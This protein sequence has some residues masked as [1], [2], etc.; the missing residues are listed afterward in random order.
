MLNNTIQSSISSNSRIAKNAILL[1][2]RMGLL[3][4][5]QLYTIPI[6]LKNL[7][8]EDY[9]VYNVIGSFVTLFSFI[10]T[11]L[12]SG[13]QRFISF[14]LGKRDTEELRKIVNITVTIYLVFAIILIVLL[15]SVG[16]WFLN[17]KM[18]I[19][20]DRIDT[21]NW[22]FQ[23]SIGA[24][25]FRLLV[26][27]YNAVIIAHEKMNF[28]AY[29]SIIDCILK[30]VS[31]ILLVY[32]L[33]D[34][35]FAYALLIWAVA[36]II[37]LMTHLYCKSRFAECHK[38]RLLWNDERKVQLLTYSGWNMIGSVAMIMRQ[39]GVNVIQNIFFGP[40]INAAHTIGQQ[41]MGGIT[42]IVNNIY[43]ASRPPITKLYA[44]GRNDDMWR[45]V[46]SSGKL[47]YFL[48][49]FI[50]IPL[51]VE[52]DTILGLWLHNVP[53][54]T[55]HI[56]RLMIIG[57]LIETLSNQIIAAYQA[58]NKIKRYQLYSSTIILCTL[59]IS[60]LWLR[61]DSASV[62]I[63]YAVSL[64][65]SVLYSISIVLNAQKEINLNLRQYCE[66]LLYKCLYVTAIPLFAVLPICYMMEAS[67]VRILIV[68][69]TTLCT[70]LL[71]VWFIG[72]ELTE[73]EQII[74]FIK[75]KTAKTY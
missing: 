2:V 74:K 17:H 51:L 56:S 25:I 41:L 52:L 70:I 28:Y 66:R 53:V 57:L 35:L 15:E 40:V 45:L 37:M 48:L 54:F 11:S 75:S 6:L 31:A 5:I 65:L 13:T 72:L 36:G 61:I 58:A 4:V 16:V 29:V 39:Q 69:A 60:Y 68:V 27:P 71:S 33:Y 62:L 19:A 24:F 12:S 50:S 38:I 34:K 44:N 3:M 20:A 30:F 49:L 32:V 42:Q 64:V 14:A 26:I 55:V 67:V 22:V 9:G 23:F 63:P 1:Y 7:G 47:A 8:V 18:Q 43:L 59:P 21:A 10:G 73:K 46:F